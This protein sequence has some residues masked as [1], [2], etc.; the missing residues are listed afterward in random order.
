MLAEVPN[1]VENG[2]A[3]RNIAYS[4]SNNNISDVTGKKKSDKNN[5]TTRNNR[6]MSDRNM[7]QKNT[8]TGKGS[9]EGNSKVNRVKNGASQGNGGNDNNDVSIDNSM[10]DENNMSD[11]ND[12]TDNNMSD[13]NNSTFDAG[14]HRESIGQVTLSLESF[15]KKT[16]R[17]NY[18]RDDLSSR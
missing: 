12:S 1:Q 13:E 6:N 18:E 17:Q 10:T 15:D 11:N 16:K 14:R 7:I 9:S 2:D 5:N 3:K 8:T 4:N